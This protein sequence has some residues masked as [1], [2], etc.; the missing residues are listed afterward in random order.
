[1]VDGIVVCPERLL[2]GKELSMGSTIL[3]VES[4]FDNKLWFSDN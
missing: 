3:K 1:M 2:L 4:S